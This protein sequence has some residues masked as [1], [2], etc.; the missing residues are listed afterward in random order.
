M[1]RFI[2]PILF[3]LSIM[4]DSNKHLESF[5]AV[6]QAA[7]YTVKNI[8]EGLDS[9][10]STVIQYNQNLN[11]PVMKKDE[12]GSQSDYVQQQPEAEASNSNTEK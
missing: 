10:Q 4:P 3:L 6:A 7:H 11:Q 12:A 5:N 9:F 1:K 8:K 2:Y